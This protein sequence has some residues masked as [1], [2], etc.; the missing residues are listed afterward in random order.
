[1]G[2]SILKPCKVCGLEKPRSHYPRRYSNPD[3]RHESCFEC[4]PENER[5]KPGR[6]A[7]SSLLC[8][9]CS[10]PMGHNWLELPERAPAH[11]HPDQRTSRRFVC[12]AICECGALWT[13]HRDNPERCRLRSPMK[14]LIEA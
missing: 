3:G 11:L 7:A 1:M 12:D 4:I 6:R 8:K 10:T 13:R 14:K 2:S 9:C 5:P